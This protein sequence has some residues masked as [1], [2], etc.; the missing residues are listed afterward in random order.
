MSYRTALNDRAELLARV[1][2]PFADLYPGDH[3]SAAEHERRW[4]LAQNEHD[5]ELARFAAEHAIAPEEAQELLAIARE[6]DTA[7]GAW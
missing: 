7:A 2:R 6:E 4:T 5:V 3:M 1:T